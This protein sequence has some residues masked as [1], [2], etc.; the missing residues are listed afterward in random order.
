VAVNVAVVVTVGVAEVT[1]GVAEITVGV[2]GSMVGADVGEQWGWPVRQAE[3]GRRP[4]RR[5][6]GDGRLRWRGAGALQV[7]APIPRV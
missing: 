2:L 6:R 1:V 4:C 7:I 3:P 5:I